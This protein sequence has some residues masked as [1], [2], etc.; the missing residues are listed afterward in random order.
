MS[1]ATETFIKEVLS[2][3]FSKTRS[4]GPGV[5]GSAGTGGG[6]TWIQSHKYRTQL[7]REEEAF[8]RGE[9]QR[10]K[11]G[12]LPTE[13][14]AASERGALG[15][16]DVRTALEM[17]DCGLGQMPVVIRQIMSGYREG[18]L[19]AYN[20]FSWPSGYG[21]QTG[22]DEALDEDVKMGNMN[23]ANG[24]NGLNGLKETHDLPTELDDFGWEGGE[25]ESKTALDNL[26]DSCL[27]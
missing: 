11:N 19:E 20:D 16:A 7:E 22:I 25:L 5:L 27:A 24:I 1:V 6:A 3:I 23:G 26:L 15:M 12:L 9:V 14:K 8:L 2:S 13:A 10:D 18:E 17:G 21:P 4:N